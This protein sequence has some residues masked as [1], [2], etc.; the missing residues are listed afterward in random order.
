MRLI[1]VVKWKIRRLQD[2]WRT[3]KFTKLDKIIYGKK[4]TCNHP[5][6]CHQCYEHGTCIHGVCL[7]SSFLDEDC[8]CEGFNSVWNKDYPPNIPRTPKPISE[9]VKE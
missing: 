8:Y 7:A 2:K 1:F 6:W 9:G 4:C 3:F 5:L